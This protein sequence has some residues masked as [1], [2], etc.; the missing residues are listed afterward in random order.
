MKADLLLPSAVPAGYQLRIEQ[1]I[2]TSKV[3]GCNRTGI[4]PDR[5]EGVD[6][7]KGSTGAEIDDIIRTY[8]SAAVATRAMH[9][10]IAF[11]KVCHHAGLYTLKPISYPSIGGL[12]MAVSLREGLSSL[13]I[14]AATGQQVFVL[15]GASIVEVSVLGGNAAPAAKSLPL[16]RAAVARLH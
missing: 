1:G 13:G 10:I 3:L 2:H 7:Q 8:P 15:T 14:T 16:I 12:T 11:A 9:Q 5:E 6:F 4:A